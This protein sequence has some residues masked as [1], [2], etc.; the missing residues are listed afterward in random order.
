VKRT[1]ESTLD[2][3]AALAADLTLGEP[4]PRLHPV[5]WMG[6]VIAAGERTLLLRRSP[7]EQL[8]GGA[9]LAL[10]VPA[11]FAA[12]AARL[13][14]ACRRIP[15]FGHVVVIWMI[16]STF[17]VRALGAAAEDV[18]SALAA[19]DV[20][21]AREGLR[22]LCSRDPA[23]LDEA[24]LAGAA[25]SSLAENASDAVVA[26]LFYMM[27]GG[28]PAAVFYRAANTMD[29]MIGY[30]GRHEWLGKAA[31][32]LDDLLNLAPAR[33]TAGLLLAAG[34][35][36]GADVRR[37]WEVFERDGGRTASPNGGRPMAAMAG[38]LGVTLV[39]EGH[40]RLGEPGAQPDPATIA[41]AWRLVKVAAGLAAALAVGATWLRG[42][43]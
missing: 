22:A 3:L 41:R 26:P 16:K 38:L 14:R 19:G 10:A 25:V 40:Y 32:R 43:R 11:L 30:R 15:V 34:A 9:V 29:A 23:E 39:K 8:V 17:S 20:G 24:G 36:T 27:W 12:G 21:R 42:R 35:L 6:R 7:T 2:L 18:R 13:R 33:L 5:V 4:P 1:R 28:L 31:A 37:G